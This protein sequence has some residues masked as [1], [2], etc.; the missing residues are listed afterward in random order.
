MT[1]KVQRQKF[2]V[3]S[4]YSLTVICSM[5]NQSWV[6]DDAKCH[7]WNIFKLENI[8]RIILRFRAN[9]LLI[10]WLRFW[11]MGLKLVFKPVLVSIRFTAKKQMNSLKHKYG[12]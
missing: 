6:S 7:S 3:D 10:N 2:A 1:S 4:F 11:F 8:D 12:V 9:L 5:R